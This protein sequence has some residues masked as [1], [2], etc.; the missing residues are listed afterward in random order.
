MAKRAKSSNNRILD[1]IDNDPVSVYLSGLAPSGRRSMRCLLKHAAE[2]LGLKGD[3]ETIPWGKLRYAHVAAVRAELM[4][5][6]RSINT[7]NT[8]LAALRGVLKSAFYLGI[9]P[10]DHLFQIDA[11]KPVKGRRLPAGHALKKGEIR[12]LFA[13]FSG[14]F[15]ARALRDHAILAMMLLAGLRRAEVVGVAVADYLPRRG[16][17][18]IQ[19]GKGN[20]QRDLVLNAKTRKAVMAWLKV[21]GREK[22]ALFCPVARGGTVQDRYLS[23]QAIY[24]IVKQRA[25]EAGIGE[26]T[27]HDLRRTFVTRLLEEGIDI[28][29]ARQLAGHQDVSTTVRYDRRGEQVGVRAMRR[30]GEDNAIYA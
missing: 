26:C 14:D 11:I 15:S 27:P 21:R 5:K 30:I 12:R 4:T 23:T 1:G 2:I 9:Y 10:A 8:T 6:K 17:L 13:V 25:V 16:R 22:G 18:I 3:L 19:Q 20:R 29:T 28:N 7:V 24:Q